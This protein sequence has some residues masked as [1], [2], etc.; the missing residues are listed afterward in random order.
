M[1]PG[2]SF[3]FAAPYKL[4]GAV[5][6]PNWLAPMIGALFM[7]AVVAGHKF[8]VESVNFH[9]TYED[10]EISRIEDDEDRDAQLEW[11]RDR[12]NELRIEHGL[13]LEGWP[14]FN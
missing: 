4:A 10:E 7:G 12:M 14:E 13:P 9:A 8:Y 5:K 2:W 11:L 1:V 3:R 6:I